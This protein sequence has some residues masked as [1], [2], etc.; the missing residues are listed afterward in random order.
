MALPGILRALSQRLNDPAP[1][2]RRRPGSA[3]AGAVGRLTQAARAARYRDCC[4]TYHGKARALGPTGR[5]A[6]GA[7][8]WLG[9]Y[10]VIGI[11]HGSSESALVPGRCGITSLGPMASGPWPVTV[12][13]G[14]AGVWA[15]ESVDK[16]LGNRLAAAR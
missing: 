1:E 11:G 16:R 9:W 10:D 12:S 6:I 14:G 7:H 4:N 15:G 5:Q 13:N 3:T 8:H 2:R